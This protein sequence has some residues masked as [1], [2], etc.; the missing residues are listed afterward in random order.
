MKSNHQTDTQNNNRGTAMPYV[1]NGCIVSITFAKNKTDESLAAA[2]E[3]L[4]SAYRV[5]TTKG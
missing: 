4:M 3:I 1:D 5:T 2:K